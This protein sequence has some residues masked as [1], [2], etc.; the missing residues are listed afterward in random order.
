MHAYVKSNNK[1]EVE[2]LLAEEGTAIVNSKDGFSQTP[3]HIAA[4]E[5]HLGLLVFLLNHNAEVDSQ[6]PHLSL[7]KD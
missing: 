1:E 5:G 6:F 3:L 2:R 7:Q 4:F